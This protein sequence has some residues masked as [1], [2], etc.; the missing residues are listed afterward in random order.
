MITAKSRK[1][2][3]DFMHLP[4][5]TRAELIEGEIYMSPTPESQHQIVVG[6]SYGLLQAFVRSGAFGR[7]FIAP[8]DVFL[9]DGEVVEPDV[10]FVAAARMG[11]VKRWVEGAPDLV[12]EVLSPSTAVRDRVVKRDLYARNGVREYWLIDPE[13]QTV[14][15]LKLER[16]AY[17]LH[18]VFESG[19][20][21][22]S[23]VLPDL[24]LPVAALFE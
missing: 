11:I 10:L 19:D 14:E 20:R 17:A 3:D 1:T 22:T 6:N 12:I 4:P 13:T 18:A 16:G 5:E 21:I 7:V 23:I 24:R 15:V 8:L 2:V 9:P